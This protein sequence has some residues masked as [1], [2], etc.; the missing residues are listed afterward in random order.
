[1]DMKRQHDCVVKC[2]REKFCRSSWLLF[3]P[4][5]L[6]SYRS[7]KRERCPDWNE[8]QQAWCRQDQ[9]RTLTA[10]SGKG[11][12][13]LNCHGNIILDCM[14]ESMYALFCYNTRGSWSKPIIGYYSSEKKFSLLSIGFLLKGHYLIFFP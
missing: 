1:M 9:R 12:A 7:S 14:S 8:E 3:F 2:E 6:A 5:C 11:N 4:G 10:T 13:Q